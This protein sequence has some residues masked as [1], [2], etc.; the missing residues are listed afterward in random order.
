MKIPLI[1]IRQMLL[2]VVRVPLCTYPKFM[3]HHHLLR[4]FRRFISSTQLA[5]FSHRV[6]LQVDKSF[7]FLG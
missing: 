2:N 3:S 4:R 6:G 7:L 1:G 5:N